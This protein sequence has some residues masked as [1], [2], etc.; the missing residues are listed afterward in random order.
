MSIA[1]L[2]NNIEQIIKGSTVPEDIAHSQNTL[3]WLLK[4]KPDA[5]E[6]LQ[7][8]ALGHDIERAVEKRKVRREDYESYDAFKRAHALNSGRILDE[9]MRRCGVPDLLPKRVFYLVCHHETGGDPD[10]DVLRDAD[11]ISF[12][13]VNLPYYFARNSLE[14]TKRR[15][16]WGYRKLPDDLK[17]VVAGFHY[18]DKTLQSLVRECIGSAEP[19]RLHICRPA[20]CS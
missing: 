3:H 14:E 8:A 19:H 20:I 15:C 2:K 10:A 16:L 17:P 12:F 18:H 11:T 4:L 1:D 7:I 9:E 6:A 5:D 13:D